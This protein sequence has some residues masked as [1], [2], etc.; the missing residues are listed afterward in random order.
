MDTVATLDVKVTADASQF[1]NE[2]GNVDKALDKSATEAEKKGAGIGR[3]FVAG[4]AV[5]SGAAITIGALA[6]GASLEW[7][8][9]LKKI[10]EKAG[11]TADEIR[12]IGAAA[13]DMA[14]AGMGK[15]QELAEQLAAA[16]KEAGNLDTAIA[17]VTKKLKDEDTGTLPENLKKLEGIAQTA[18]IKIG[19]PLTEALKPVAT[20]AATVASS[21]GDW[22]DKNPELTS[23][24]L[25]IGALALPASVGIRFIAGAIG[26][27][28]AVL[29]S[30]LLANMAT[31]ASAVVLPALPAIIAAAGIAGAYALIAKA[32]AD[33]EAAAKRAHDAVTQSGVLPEGDP[34]AGNTAIPPENKVNTTPYGQGAT[35]YL[36]ASP[37]LTLLA[38]MGYTPSTALEALMQGGLEPSEVLNIVA[39]LGIP[40]SSTLQSLVDAGILPS[41]V[42]TAAMQDGLGPNATL[43]DY[44]NNG[45]DAS[46]YLAALLAE[47]LKVS[48]SVDVNSDGRAAARPVSGPRAEGGDT[49]MGSTYLIGENGPELWT[50]GANGFIT[51]MDVFSG[52]GGGG[53]PII[54]QNLSIFANSVEELYDQIRGEAGRRGERMAFA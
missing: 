18:L 44:L 8:N 45:I 12:D 11:L 13:L 28:N 32:A 53:A 21:I 25:T 4:A 52:G 46:N 3:A 1:Q 7:E 48:V 22:I 6:F 23:Q 16:Y 50:A 43:Q 19:T 30:T 29:T 35:T 26:A 17:N 49:A 10:Q 27:V 40:P 39:A 24:I 31:F 37:N 14:A 42:L 38:A 33:A 36:E 47:G 34:L 5:I 15:P 9:G 41:A 54:I 51:P 2:L 20:Q